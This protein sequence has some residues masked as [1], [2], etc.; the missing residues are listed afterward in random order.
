MTDTNQK[1]LGKALW[2]IADQVKRFERKR[3]LLGGWRGRG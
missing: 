2:G 1:Q 3:R